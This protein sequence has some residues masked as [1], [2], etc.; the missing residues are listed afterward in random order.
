MDVIIYDD[1]DDDDDCLSLCSLF[2]LLQCVQ[3]ESNVKY[4]SNSGNSQPVIV[5]FI[6]SMTIVIRR[7]DKTRPERAKIPEARQLAP[8][9]SS[10]YARFESIHFWLNQM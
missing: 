6:H 2:I 8:S 7:Q 4:K 3:Y 1:D 5:G 10:S 9:S